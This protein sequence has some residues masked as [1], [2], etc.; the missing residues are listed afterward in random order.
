MI[1]KNSLL[2][3][4][5]KISKSS[6]TNSYIKKSNDTEYRLNENSNLDKSVESKIIKISGSDTILVDIEE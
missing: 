2:P 3:L 1:Y 4:C 6:K 5:Y